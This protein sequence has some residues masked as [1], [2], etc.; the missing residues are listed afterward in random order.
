MMK[1]MKSGTL[2]KG[3]CETY[4]RYYK[5]SKEEDLACMGFIVTVRLVEQGFPLFAP[6]Q[7]ATVSEKRG[8]EMPC[9]ETAEALRNK[10]CAVCLFQENDCDFMDFHRSGQSAG[11]QA[12]PWPC[13]GFIY[14]GLLLDRKSIDI[15]DINQVA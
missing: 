14:L 2:S 9:D 6:E 5:P 7:L 15:E 12:V 1:V 10:V 8:P 3:L 4:C 13:G 11:Q